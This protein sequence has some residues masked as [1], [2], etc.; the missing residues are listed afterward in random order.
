MKMKFVPKCIFV[1]MAS[2]GVALADTPVTITFDNLPA[3]SSPTAIPNGYGGFAWVNFSYLDSRTEQGG[4]ANGA[5]SL[6]NVAFNPGG[7]PAN[8]SSLTPFNLA[9]ADLTGAWND[10]LQVEVQ[11]FAHGLVLY[12]HTY[13]VNATGPTLINFNYLGVTEVNFISFGGAPH[14]FPFG[15]GTQFVLDNLIVAAP[16]PGTAGLLCLGATLTGM[17]MLRA[18]WLPRAAGIL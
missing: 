7:N 11:G 4:F 3:V 1:L 6:Y 9:S 12:D 2:A 17:A 16:E 18:K 15:Q 14:G 13:S 8:F 5:V 10:G